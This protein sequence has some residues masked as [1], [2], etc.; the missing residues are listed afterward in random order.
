MILV[1]TSISACCTYYAQVTVAL[2]VFLRKWTNPSSQRLSWLSAEV[3]LLVTLEVAIA[4]DGLGLGCDTTCVVN[5]IKL[6]STV[7]ET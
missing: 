5:T 2:C 7:I 3:M 1:V 4:Q 6:S